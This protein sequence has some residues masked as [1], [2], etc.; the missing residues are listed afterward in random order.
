VNPPNLLTFTGGSN[1][2]PVGWYTYNGNTAPY[3]TWSDFQSI[4]NPPLTNMHLYD[5]LTM[6]NQSAQYWTYHGVIGPVSDLDANSNYVSISYINTSPSGW[7]QT[8]PAPDP[9][10]DPTPDPSPAPTPDPDPDPDPDPTPAP[11]TQNDNIIDMGG[12]DNQEDPSP[13]PDPA[14]VVP[15]D[16]CACCDEIQ[17]QLDSH[18]QEIQTL[19]NEMDT[20]L[21]DDHTHT[22][23][24]GHS[25]NTGDHYHVLDT[26]HG[27]TY[28]ASNS[29]TNVN[30][31]NQFNTET[32]DVST[33]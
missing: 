1:V 30:T 26:V 14:P 33:P 18:A 19:H 16:D 6:P 23:T 12:D 32:Q 8:A 17:Q 24:H 31:N 13:D 27:T 21:G 10:P 3:W 4:F 20:V 11:P 25:V 22:M 7:S 2:N 29:W 5:P 9:T 28:G 15:P